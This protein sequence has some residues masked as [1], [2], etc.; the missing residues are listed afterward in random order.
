[1]HIIVIVVNRKL[2]R[3]VDMLLSVF[4]QDMSPAKAKVFLSCGQ[5]GLMAHNNWHSYPTKPRALEGSLK[6]ITSQSRD[7]VPVPIST[8]QQRVTVRNHLAE[9]ITRIGRS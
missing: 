2:G 5:G 8:P 3:K 4:P 7:M 9:F 6:L 1:M